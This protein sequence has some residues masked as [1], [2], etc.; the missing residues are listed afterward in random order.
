ETIVEKRL[1]L[2]QETWHG[3]RCTLPANHEPA[4]PHRFPVG[5]RA[6]FQRIV[7][8]ALGLTYACREVFLLCDIQGFT[9]SKAAGFL[10]ISPAVVRTRLNQARR[11][12]HERLRNQEVIPLSPLHP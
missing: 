4:E 12:M 3:I 5:E 8:N 11:E 1:D 7:T 2:C 6:E 9:I 10:G